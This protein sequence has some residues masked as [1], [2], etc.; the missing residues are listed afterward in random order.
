M[1]GHIQVE[2]FGEVRACALVLR[3]A[4]NECTGIIVEHNGVVNIPEDLLPVFDEIAERHGCDVF[5]A[6]SNSPA[7]VWV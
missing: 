6:F 5:E 4:L 2:I 7:R 1:S 3:E